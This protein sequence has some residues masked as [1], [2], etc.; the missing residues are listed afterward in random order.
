VGSEASIQAAILGCLALFSTVIMYRN[1]RG[2]AHRG[3]R[4][5]SFGL[6]KGASDL[7]GVILGGR[8]FC[9]EVKKPGEKPTED[10]ESF[11]ADIRRMG[12]FACPVES[13]TGAIAALGRALKGMTE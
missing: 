12:G 2:G 11:M 3:G 6:G 8:V 1:N 7:I 4:Y 5:I 13:T 10:Q 9:L